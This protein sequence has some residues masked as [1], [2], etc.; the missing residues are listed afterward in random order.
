MADSVKFICTNVFFMTDTLTTLARGLLMLRLPP[1]L[2]PRPTPGMDTTEATDTP[3]TAT[4]PGPTMVAT[5]S[6]SDLLML[7]LPLLLPPKLMP[8]PTLGMDTTD[9]DTQAT[10]TDTQAGAVTTGTGGESR[11]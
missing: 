11:Y 7:R 4:P 8:R 10:A 3:I 1:L 6:A 5:G 2:M 9:G